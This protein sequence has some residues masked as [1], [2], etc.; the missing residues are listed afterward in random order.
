M[1]LT[2][3]NDLYLCPTDLAAYFLFPPFPVLPTSVSVCMSR[4][5]S[6]FLSSDDDE[7]DDESDSRGGPFIRHGFVPAVLNGANYTAAAGF[8]MDQR[9][10]CLM[11][12]GVCIFSGCA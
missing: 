11:S 12:N 2:Y 7:Q 9:G 10:I 8:M 6:L 3:S 4:N 5:H 1:R